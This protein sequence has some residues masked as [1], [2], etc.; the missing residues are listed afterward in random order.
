MS[1][2]EDKLQHS[3]LNYFS[4]QAEAGLVL[5]V[6]STPDPQ[7]IVEL[8]PNAVLQCLHEQPPDKVKSIVTEPTSICDAAASDH[9]HNDIGLAVGH[10]LSVEDRIRY[11][12]PWTP[13][14]AS[15]FLSSVW[16]DQQ[17]HTKSGVERRRRLLPRHLEDFPWLAVSRVNPGAFCIPCV[18]FTAS[19]AGVGGRS[20]GHG[21]DA[22][23][24]VMK[25][26]DHFDNLTGKDGSLTR[27]AKTMYHQDAILAFDD[28]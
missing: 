25:P 16:V 27:H 14:Y 26:L 19:G 18:L 21:Q 11:L 24:L 5:P 2:K 12:E 6:V 28:F 22:G 3:V 7:P 1:G 20:L 23:K 9:Y 15:E 4:V 13:T 17:S 10:Q 8:Q